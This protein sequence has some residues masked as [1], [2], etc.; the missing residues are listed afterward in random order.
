MKLRTRKITYYA[1]TTCF[2]IV[3]TYLVFTTQGLVIDWENLKVVKTGGIYL[4]YAPSDANIFINKK[5]QNSSPGIISRG[6]FIKD[7][8]PKKYHIKIVRDEYHDWE[9]YLEVLSGIVTPESSIK[10][11]RKEQ[12]EKIIA[13]SSIENFWITGAGII[14]KEK[15]RGLLINATPMRGET[16]IGSSP[17]IDAVI[18]KDKKGNLFF[19]DLNSPNGAINIYE[20]FNS[21]IK[22]EVKTAIAAKIDH[23][24]LHP[25]SARKIVI[26]TKNSLY[27]LDLKKIQLE[28]IATASST[29][30]IVAT[31]NEIF[32]I[33]KNGNAVGTNLLIGTKINIKISSTSTS[34]VYATKNGSKFFTINS[35]GELYLFE[36]GTGEISFISK[37]IGEVFL[38]PDE[39]KLA[40]VF[41]DNSIKILYL[42][43]EKG[44]IKIAKGSILPLQLTLNKHKNVQIS[45]MPK[46]W[47]YILAFDGDNLTVTEIDNRYPQNTHV[48]FTKIK[49]Y[50]LTS[51]LYILREDGALSTIE[52]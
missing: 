46:F 6:V 52:L 50:A 5:N 19:V 44:D 51:T 49:E 37:N 15:E 39:K 25:F 47:N 27:S 10:L 26:A 48:L 23:V 7:L 13:S 32:L 41:D 30:N 8:A 2:V 31:G 12:K 24:I 42:E 11:W 40:L 38:S 29:E 14:I 21:L 18:T 28:K 9:K 33:D 43:E 35:D 1:L 3:G 45:W 36:R 20:I 34:K 22:R 17:N 16:I 4:K